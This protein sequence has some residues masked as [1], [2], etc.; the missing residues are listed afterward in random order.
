MLQKDHVKYILLFQNIL[1]DAW[2]IESNKYSNIIDQIDSNTANLNIKTDE[3]KTKKKS[4]KPKNNVKKE[5]I[6]IPNLLE[7]PEIPEI[8]KDELKE[9]EVNNIQPIINEIDNEI[10]INDTNNE[11]NELLNIIPNAK[12]LDINIKNVFGINLQDLSSSQL[13]ALESFHLQV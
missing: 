4:K 13:D 10:P 5:I 1:K 11:I 2:D 12:E 3:K 6:N 9:E 8:Q 7:I